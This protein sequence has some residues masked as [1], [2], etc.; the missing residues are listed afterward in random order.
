MHKIVEYGDGMQAQ[1]RF[2]FQYTWQLCLFSGSFGPLKIT[3]SRVKSFGGF[4]KFQG[5]SIGILVALHEI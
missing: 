5:H 1:V 2:C 3:I 4:E